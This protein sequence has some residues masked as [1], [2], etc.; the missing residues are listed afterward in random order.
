MT[1]GVYAP[2]ATVSMG[3]GAGGTG[4]NLTIQFV[5][6]DLA[7]QGTPTFHFQYNSDAFPRPMGY[8]LV[9]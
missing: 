6:W 7:L 2:K 4:G 9:Q 8:G 1:G 5:S 3:G